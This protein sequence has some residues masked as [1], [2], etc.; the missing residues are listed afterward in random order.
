MRSGKE[1]AKYI[2]NITPESNMVVDSWINE[3]VLANNWELRQIPIE[4][5]LLD[6][7]FKEAWE[8]ISDEDDLRYDEYTDDVSY[9]TYK[10]PIVLYQDKDETLLI[11]GYS[12]TERHLWNGEDTI[13]AYVNV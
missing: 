9:D 13:F 7:S 10:L 5:V 8:Y 11:D 1:I 6:P 3:F 2:N 12:R 4:T